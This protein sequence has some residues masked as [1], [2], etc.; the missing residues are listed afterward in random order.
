MKMKKNLNKTKNNWNISFL[1]KIAQ[2]LK[3][4]L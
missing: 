4:L 3:I 2:L 1:Y